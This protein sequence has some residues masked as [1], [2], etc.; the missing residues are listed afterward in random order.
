[1]LRDSHGVLLRQMHTLLVAMDRSVH[2]DRQGGK[3]GL[4]PKQ[5]SAS[6]PR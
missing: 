4:R 2:A 6:H 3:T 5:P 1:M